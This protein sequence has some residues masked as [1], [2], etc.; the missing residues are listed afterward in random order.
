MPNKLKCDSCFGLYPDYLYIC[1]HRTVGKYVSM[2]TA[3]A[4]N[5]DAN[6]MIMMIKL[7]VMIMAI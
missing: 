3:S 2:G 7:I 1:I 4:A 5:D 6:I